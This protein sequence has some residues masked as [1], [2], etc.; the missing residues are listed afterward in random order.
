MATPCCCRSGGGGLCCGRLVCRAA[1]RG[2]NSAERLTPSP[3]DIAPLTV[4]VEHRALLI[5]RRVAGQFQPAQVTS[6]SATLPV[7]TQPGATQP[8]ITRLPAAGTEIG[9]GAV[10]Y[11]VS[12]RP[13]FAVAGSTPMYRDLLAGARGRDVDEVEAMLVAAG[14]PLTPDGTI[15]DDDVAAV[16]GIYKAAG[17][18]AP[19]AGAGVV[20]PGGEV[21]VVPSLPV[22]VRTVTAQ[23]GGPAS[24][25]ILALGSARLVVSCALAPAD[26]ARVAAG[27]NASVIATDGSPVAATIVSAT[28]LSDGSG[29]ADVRL[30]TS[31]ELP[32]ARA[33]AGAL[34]EFNFG[35]SPDPVLVVPVSAIATRA[36]GTSMVRVA[37]GTTSTDVPVTVG[38]TSDGYAAITSAGA[39]AAGDQV[40]VG[41]SRQ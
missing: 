2:D 5:Q 28:P 17:Y 22:T 7:L 41:V 30:E 18:E 32:D 14:A 21:V 37:H 29:G 8:L 9:A 15:G 12:G 26:A 36:D 19:P 38:I 20:I 31:S 1:C 39:L 16:A 23:L 35:G 6:V 27:D 13:V 4:A 34:V 25:E 3:R 10:L 33:G 40:V 11:E 24:G